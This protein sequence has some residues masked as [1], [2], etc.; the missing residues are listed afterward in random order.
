MD[1]STVKSTR[2]RQSGSQ[3]VRRFGDRTASVWAIGI[4]IALVFAA[5]VAGLAVRGE[6]RTEVL[7]D[8][9]I[10]QAAND[11]HFYFEAFF[12]NSLEHDALAQIAGACRK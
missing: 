4:A 9:C 8:R 12:Q 2:K 6:H 5:V 1:Q 10:S 7:E 3:R 11:S